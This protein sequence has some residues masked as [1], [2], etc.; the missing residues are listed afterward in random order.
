MS[1]TNA[2]GGMDQLNLISELL[3]VD[4]DGPTLVEGQ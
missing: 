3:S 4:G 1:S 2:I